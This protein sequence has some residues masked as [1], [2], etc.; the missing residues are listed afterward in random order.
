MTDSDS[1]EDSD[2]GAP[3]VSYIT[4]RFARLIGSLVLLLAGL[5]YC[6]DVE[7]SRSLGLGAFAALLNLWLSGRWMRRLV[8]PRGAVVTNLGV[9]LLKLL[10][11]LL[12]AYLMI[13]VRIAEPFSLGLAFVSVTMLSTLLLGVPQRGSST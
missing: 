10:G 12:L 8:T 13:E 11:L 4:L 6:C 9:L 1:I 7:L 2:S 5:S 3:R